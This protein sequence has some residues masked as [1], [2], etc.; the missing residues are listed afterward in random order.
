MG[1][2]LGA[3]VILY[4]AGATSLPW[5]YNVKSRGYGWNGCIGGRGNVW[6]DGDARR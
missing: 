4:D 2:R 1:M 5:L 6:M 3:F